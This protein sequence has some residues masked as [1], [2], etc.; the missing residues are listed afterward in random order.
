M[1]RKDGGEN[2]I[3]D[4]RKFFEEGKYGRPM[5]QGEFIAFWKS[6]SA[7]EKLEFMNADLAA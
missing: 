4:I 1:E 5:K 6:L 2:S 7:E 3:V